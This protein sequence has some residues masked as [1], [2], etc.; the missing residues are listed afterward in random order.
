MAT[1]SLCWNGSSRSATLAWTSSTHSC[2]PFLSSPAHKPSWITWRRATGSVCARGKRGVAVSRPLTLCGMPE[3][4]E[5]AVTTCFEGLFAMS[6]CSYPITE[7]PTFRADQQ[8][9]AGQW[10]TIRQTP[11]PP[12]EAQGHNAPSLQEN[13]RPFSRGTQVSNS[14]GCPQCIHQECVWGAV[15]SQALDLQA[16]LCEHSST[17]LG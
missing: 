7:L 8:Q 17:Q 10:Q 4:C 3:V 14:G 2:L 6:E 16:L 9:T 12:S 15:C 1:W 5:L 13:V 11:Q